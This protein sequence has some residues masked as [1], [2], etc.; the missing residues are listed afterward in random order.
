MYTKDQYSFLLSLARDQGYEFV[1]FLQQSKNSRCIYLRHDVDHSLDMALELA[2][3][4]AALE[5]QGTFFLL[6]RS[7]VYNLLSKWV[8]ARAREIMSLGQRLA[9]HCSL[10]A[11]ELLE[12]EA[13]C[14]LVIR[15]FEIVRNEL[16]EVDPVFSWHNPPPAL[17]QQSLG[18]QVKGLIN[19]YG[20]QFVKRV[21]YYS[22][23]NMRYS[24]SEFA[25]FLS[26]DH[27]AI[28]LLFHPCN[29]VAEGKD[30]C[31]VLAKTWQ[32]I[33]KEREYEIVRNTTYQRVMPGG[34]PESVLEEFSCSWI[35][36]TLQENSQAS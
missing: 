15:D 30:M 18:L 33:I 23:S 26:S 34:I 3:W 4:N 6:L 22:D 25:R 20:E 7:Q 9:F 29:W 32:H 24:V 17:L 2:K 12:E 28:H 19:V 21:P 14:N 16:P 35:N 8:L 13:L 11:D 5:V 36:A 1:S 27:Q 10:S 31:D